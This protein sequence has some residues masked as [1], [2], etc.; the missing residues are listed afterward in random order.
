MPGLSPIFD[1][2]ALSDKLKRIQRVISTSRYDVARHLLS[3]WGDSAS[4]EGNGIQ[5]A[6]FYAS[7]SE[8]RM[9][10]G[11]SDFL[12][13]WINVAAEIIDDSGLRY[14]GL[15]GAKLFEG[16][17]NIL[18]AHPRGMMHYELAASL[19][20][21]TATCVLPEL[22]VYPLK[23]TA[24]TLK[25]PSFLREDTICFERLATRFQLDFNRRIH[26]RGNATLHSILTDFPKIGNDIQIFLSNRLCSML[27]LGADPCAANHF[28]LT[29]T[30]IALINNL[31]EIWFNA[32]ISSSIDLNC[33][34]KHSFLELHK[35]EPNQLLAY[36]SD[37]KMMTPSGP[38]IADASFVSKLQQ[39][40]L[41]KF[42]EFGIYPNET[43]F[44]TGEPNIYNLET[45]G[46]DFLPQTMHD[47]ARPNGHIR[48]RNAC[49]ADDD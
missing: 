25:D 23:A 13:Q 5:I 48:R 3:V 29:P 17:I 19:N 47:P 4:P 36:Q 7:L 27:K 24:R 39:H 14:L 45:S 18:L 49:F 6:I 22:P 38:K 11:L 10:K 2:T 44:E 37:W 8:I 34:A 12:R 40:S 35:V 21:I 42:A 46:V 30:M 16:W 26:G 20:R 32:L 33:V 31:I 1:C 9:G 15:H 41:Q 28:H 43:W